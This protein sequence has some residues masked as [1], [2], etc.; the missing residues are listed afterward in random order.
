MRYFNGYDFLTFLQIAGKSRL[1]SVCSILID[2]ILKNL[3]SS[4]MIKFPQEVF[5]EKT[6]ETLQ[7]LSLRKDIDHQKLNA[8]FDYLLS[9][10]SEVLFPA[11]YCHG[12]LTLSNL[13][14]YKFEDKL[15]AID[16]LDNFLDS[17]IQD[18][19]K[20]R[21]DTQFFWSLLLYTGNIDA[22]K[23]KL[24]FEYMDKRL[25]LEIEEKF[26]MEIF[27]KPFQILSLLRVL[28]YTTEE[29]MIKFLYSSIDQLME[30]Q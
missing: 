3:D 29:R 21:Q 9:F 16:F 28:K 26:N 20:L 7:I 22:T 11:G 30:K 19:V 17:P 23:T 12:D 14:V 10:S 5:K 1:D 6:L 2:F 24:A 25:K 4:I 15:M 13:L 18:Y 27:Y 8:Y